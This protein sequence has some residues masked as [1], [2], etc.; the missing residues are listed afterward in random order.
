MRKKIAVGHGHCILYL[1]VVKSNLSF[2]VYKLWTKN[3]KLTHTNIMFNYMYKPRTLF[4]YRKLKGIHPNKHNDKIIFNQSS[5]VSCSNI[6]NIVIFLWYLM[7]LVLCTT[8]IGVTYYTIQYT[9]VQRIHWEKICFFTQLCNHSVFFVRI[10]S[11]KIFFFIY[12][13]EMRL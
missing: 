9:I 12:A 11:A 7:I 4:T 13:H 1:Q 10:I 3:T 2:H 6:T 8:T 5:A